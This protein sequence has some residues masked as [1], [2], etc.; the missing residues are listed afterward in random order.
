MNLTPVPRS[1]KVSRMNDILRTAYTGL[2]ALLAPLF[3]FQCSEP[4]P[5]P[6]QGYT[7]KLVASYPHD[8]EAFTQGLCYENGFLY[9]GTG[10]Y[11]KSSLRKV[12]L[13]TGKV[14]QTQSLDAAYFGEGIAIVGDRIVQLTWQS[15]I[16]F[17]YDKATFQQIQDFHYETEGWGLTYD[18]ARLIMSDGSSTLRFLDPATFAETGTLAVTDSGVPVSQL[19]ELEYV[20]GEIYANVWRTSR[21]ARIAPATGNVVGWI[22]L[23]NLVAEVRAEYTVDVLNGIAY[24]AETK[25]LFIT[26]KLWPKIYEFEM[27][28]VK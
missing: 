18:G 1:A 8:P 25:R 17:V 21:I 10:R 2:V 27:I 7:Y 23:D 4:P 26:G 3:L 14:L 5:S 9:E 20:E 28:P 11:G 24:N 16:G 6:P 19:N 13:E 12:E 15:K 22:N